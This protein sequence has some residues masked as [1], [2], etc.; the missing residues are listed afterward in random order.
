MKADILKSLLPVLLVTL[1][2]ILVI[3]T[4]WSQILV[5]RIKNLKEK[6]DN[7]DND[8]YSSKDPY[9]VDDEIEDLSNAIDDMKENLKKQEEYKNQL[10]QNISHDF[11]TPL[12][13]IKSYVEAVDDDVEDP[14]TA[15]QVIKDQTDKLENKVHLSLIHI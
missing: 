9:K 8:E 15:L 11:K 12:T 6:V 7:L 14:L 4:V 13:V 2:I 3:V 10:Y 5:E 1:L